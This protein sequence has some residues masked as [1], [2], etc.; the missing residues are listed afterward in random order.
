MPRLADRLAQARRRA[1]AGRDAEIGLFRGL[2]DPPGQGAV[3]HVHGPG[4]IGKTTLLR[5]FAH[6]GA[7]AGRT[8]A[9]LDCRDVRGPADVLAGLAPGLEAVPS[10]LLVLDTAEHLAPLDQWLRED[11]LSGLGADAI[12]V[13]GGREPPATVWRTDPGWRGLTRTIGLGPLAPDESRALLAGHGVPESGFD[14]ALRCAHGHP[15]ALSL[16]ADVCTQRGGVVPLTEDPQL[17]TALL[18]VLLG[19]V[20]SARHRAALEACAL[21][22]AL[23]EPLLAALLDVGDAREEFAW[24]RGLSITEYGPRGVF[25]HDLAREALAAE[26]RWRDPVRYR[27]LHRRAGAY[28][29]QQLAGAGPAA[30]QLVLADFAFLHRDSPV[31][32]PFLAALRPGAGEGPGLRPAGPADWPALRALV[33]RHEGPES[34]AIAEHWFARQPAATLVAGDRAGFATVLDISRADPSDRAA[35]PGTDAACRYLEAHGPLRDGESAA[36]IRFWLDA[37]AYQQISATQTALTLHL[38]RYYLTAP[39][40]AFTFLP[41]A[42]PDAWAAACAYLDL[43]RLPE[44]DFT[45]GERRFGVFGHD[46]RTVPPMAWLALLAEREV[47]GAPPDA[48]PSPAAAMRVLDEE[49]FASAVRDA[50][51]QLGRADRLARS[52]LLHSRLVGARAGADAARAERIAA[53]QSAVREAAATLDSS[54]RDRRLHRVLHHTYL[55]PAPTQQAAADLLQLPMTTYRRHLAAATARVTAALWESELIAR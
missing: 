23:T 40:L 29:Q 17:V 49:E 35:D 1:F 48:P 2:L 8:L 16:I 41:Y 9:W 12:T 6:L 32:A 33:E 55:Q 34:A 43:R 10:L 46:W 38:V 52:P 51:R 45:T 22:S 39:G 42:D 5:E 31:L 44:A 18:G 54:P 20:P 15:L 21:V 50:L 19:A 30:Q 36:L 11:L 47:A 7:D 14:D 24:L 28:Y 25:P 27:E 26:T 13:I 4:G 37:D 3:V 53:L